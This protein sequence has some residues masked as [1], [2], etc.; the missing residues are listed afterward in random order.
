MRVLGALVREPADASEKQREASRKSPLR[1]LPGPALKAGCALV[2][3]SGPLP[4]PLR[5]ATLR[6]HLANLIDEDASLARNSSSIGRLTRD[7]LLEACADRGLG[8]SRV[9]DS[10]LRREL[11]QWLALV[12]AK[13]YASDAVEPHRLRLAAL[14]ALS[15]TRAYTL[16]T[17][18][19]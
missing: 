13:G 4:G 6:K 16:L 5:R 14:A 3:V 17:P 2:G 9:R 1:K 12:G 19:V 8:G 7:Q 15:F 10:E 18:A 11:R